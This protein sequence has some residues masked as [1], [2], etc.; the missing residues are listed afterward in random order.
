[1]DLYSILLARM[2]G[3]GAELPATT[4]LFKGDGSGGAVEAV[5]GTDY[6]T[7]ST[8]ITRNLTEADSV[9]LSDNTEYILSGAA[10]DSVDFEY[11]SGAFECYI[12]ITTKSNGTTVSFP[13]GTQYIGTVPQFG[14]GE[15]WEISVKDGIVVAGK[16]GSGS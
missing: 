15:T 9:E 11:P 5:P 8:R 10:C 16:V 13:T 4:N 14:G 12:R 2:A 3:G 6:L 1:M 7:P